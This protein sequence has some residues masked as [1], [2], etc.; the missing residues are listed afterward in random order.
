MKKQ[1]IQS[2]ILYLESIIIEEENKD[3]NQTRFKIQKTKTVQS[4]MR[5]QHT[6]VFLYVSVV[7]LCNLIHVGQSSAHNPKRF[8]RETKVGL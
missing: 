6:S 3:F 4:V 7:L 2:Y 8:P 5:T 1:R